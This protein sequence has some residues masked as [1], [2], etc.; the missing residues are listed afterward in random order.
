[1]TESI[2]I[3][4]VGTDGSPTAGRA[5]A[6]AF[7]LAERFGARVVVLSAFHAPGSA[8]NPR[9]SGGTSANPGW[10]SNAAEQVERI[11][12]TAEESA[13]ARGLDC[14]TAVREGDPGEVLVSLAEEHGA[15]VLVVGNKGMERRVL[16]SVPNTVSHKATCSVLIVKTS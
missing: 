9:L 12:A 6:A 16:G 7:E 5:L 1:M 11:L 15:D 4:A 3:V 8:R 13:A 14:S 2:S 10:A